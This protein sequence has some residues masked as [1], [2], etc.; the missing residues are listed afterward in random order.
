MHTHTHTLT[1]AAKTHSRTATCSVRGHRSGS[2]G[3]PFRHSRA[4]QPLTE[5]SQRSAEQ[6]THTHTHTSPLL[7]CA[8]QQAEFQ[9]IQP[10]VSHFTLF[11]LTERKTGCD[12]NVEVSKKAEQYSEKC[13]EVTLAAGLYT[14]FPRQ[15][16]EN[17]YC[18]SPLICKMSLQCSFD[19]IKVDKFDYGMN[20]FLC[21]VRQ[22]L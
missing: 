18:S 9:T 10:P 19:H 14:D 2:S 22:T 17:D 8:S 13:R 12:R 7:I 11:S 4:L 6:P 5:L 20:T 21:L 15:T 1:H 16:H 3:S